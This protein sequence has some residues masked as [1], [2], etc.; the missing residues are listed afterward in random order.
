MP[1]E[2]SW[3][4]YQLMVLGELKRMNDAIK[5]VA[6][7]VEEHGQ[8]LSALPGIKTEMGKMNDTITDHKVDVAL[9]KLKAGV[10]GLLG[11]IIP[12]TVAIIMW[13]LNRKG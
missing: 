2:G 3:S 10:W 12:A 8:S 1:G 7:K 4:E 6:D 5:E 11:G 9:L 13:L